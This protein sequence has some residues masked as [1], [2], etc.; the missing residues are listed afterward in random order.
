MVISNHGPQFVSGF[1]KELNKALGIEMKLSTAYHPQTD[2]QTEG[3]NQELKQYLRMSV[4]YHQMNWPEWLA[5][6][7]FPY[8]NKIQTSTKMLPFYANYGFNPH[9]GI[10]PQREVKIQAVD[11]FIEL[12]K[13]QGEAEAALCKAHD[14]MKCFAD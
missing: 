3:I 13:I 1:M 11:R 14:N 8:N 5:I 6:A 4:D 10:E 12:R 9:M 2:G 7:E